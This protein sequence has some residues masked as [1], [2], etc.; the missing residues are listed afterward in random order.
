MQLCKPGE[1]DQKKENGSNVLDPGWPGT[2]DGAFERWG[3]PRELRGGGEPGSRAGTREGG[4]GRWRAG[5]GT[6]KVRL[7]PEAVGAET[8]SV[9]C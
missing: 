2:A 1:Q 9:Y 6:G 3:G 8:D 4:L 5:V 7:P